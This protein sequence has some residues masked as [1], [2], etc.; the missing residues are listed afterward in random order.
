MFVKNKGQRVGNAGGHREKGEDIDK[1][2][3]RE[4]CEETGIISESLCDY[5]VQDKNHTNYGRLFCRYLKKINDPEVEEVGSLLRFLKFDVPKGQKHFSKS[6]SLTKIK[7]PHAAK[8][9][10]FCRVIHSM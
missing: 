10:I 4:L 7:P 2:G 9:T 1:T 8:T 5:S 3:S 6:I